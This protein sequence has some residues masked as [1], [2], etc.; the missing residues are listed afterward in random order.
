MTNARIIE[1]IERRIRRQK[2]KLRVAESER[3][4]YETTTARAK[5]TE[6][7]FLLDFIREGS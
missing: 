1:E 3:L 4:T 6:L 2:S 7:T 5:I